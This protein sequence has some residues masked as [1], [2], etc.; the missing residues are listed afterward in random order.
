[1]PRR[2]RRNE[3]PLIDDTFAILREAPVW[4]GPILAAV[5]YAFCRWAFPW[6]MSLLINGDSAAD[7]GSNVFAGVSRTIS[8]L[9]GLGVLLIWV[10]AEITKIV[11]RRRF[12]GVSGVNSLNGLGWRDFEALLAEAFRREGFQ[13]ERS[14]GAGPD[15]GID[16]RLNKAGAVTLVQCKHWK[17]SSVGVK[18]V[19]ELQG[20]VSAEQAQSGIVVT[21]GRFTREAEEFVER[22]PIRLIAGEELIRM[23]GKAQKSGRIRKHPDK[24]S[25]RSGTPAIGRPVDN[26]DPHR[27]P[28][29]QCGGVMV[30]RVAKRGTNAGSAFLGCSRYPDCKGTRNIEHATTFK[31]S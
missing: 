31:P 8:P 6:L 27:P 1:M 20:V 13:I 25:P 14:G 4:L 26:D 28:C 10:V 22:I 21:S 23:I 16:L 11:D 7:I 2:N 24:P 30:R 19:R 9:L 12:E 17:K 18:V 29:P 15:G 5:V 3:S